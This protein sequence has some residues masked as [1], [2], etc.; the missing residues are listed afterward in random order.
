MARTHLHL[1]MGQDAE[2]EKEALVKLAE[3]VVEDSEAGQRSTKVSVMFRM[4]GLAMLAH[5]LEVVRAMRQ[6]RKYAQYQ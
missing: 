4:L 3:Q 6:I 1:F 5:P 2:Q